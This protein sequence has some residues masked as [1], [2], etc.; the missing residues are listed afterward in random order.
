[1]TTII[2]LTKLDDPRDGIH[3]AVQAL[4]EGACVELPLEEG[5]VPCL[6]A[7]NAALE[8][9]EEVSAIAGSVR[10]TSLLTVSLD[11][12]TDFLPELTPTQARVF[13]RAYPGQSIFRVDR[14]PA[15]PVDEF[16][17]WVQRAV[18]TDTSTLLRVAGRTVPAAVL[19]LLPAPLVAGP[20]AGR[21]EPALRLVDHQPAIGQ[22]SVIAMVGGAVALE[23]EHLIDGAELKKLSGVQIVLVCTG[24]TCRSP[25]AE[26]ALKG[27]LAEHLGIALDRLEDAGVTVVSAGV[28]TGGGSP[29]S[30]EAVR[31][32]G[33]LGLDLSQHRSRAATVELLQQ[34][35]AVYT[36]TQGH[37]ATIVRQAPFLRDAVQTLVPDGRDIDD[38]IGG[39]A[40]V[41]QAC[42]K[43]IQA[44]L[45]QRLAELAP[46]VDEI[47][48][49][50]R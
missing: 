49:T 1:M 8:D 4:V 20:L 15:G 45:R 28:A 35:D 10:P 39:Q 30:P 23:Q 12:A 46:L 7:T 25:M 13:L 37:R 34:A 5:S 3:Q 27:M 16:P 21:I 40:S 26:V 44:A 6:L 36:M 32:V 9:S 41:Y 33:Q 24:N 2:D 38:P 11:A 19:S 29:A 14:V 48:E 42:L 22:P 18:A 43:Q 50:G 47:R 31:A 17:G